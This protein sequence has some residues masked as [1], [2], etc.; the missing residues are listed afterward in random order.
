MQSWYFGM[1]LTERTLSRNKTSRC[2]IVWLHHRV[3][4]S[5]SPVILAH[6]ILGRGRCA[7]HPHK[8][9]STTP[10][11]RLLICPPNCSVPALLSLLL[12]RGQMDEPN[13]NLWCTHPR[14][15]RFGD[16]DRDLVV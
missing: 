16:Y 14:G 5:G 3:D 10:I 7:H 4:I 12:Q 13:L 11:G 6:A 2:W 9:A 1:H 15:A 8:L